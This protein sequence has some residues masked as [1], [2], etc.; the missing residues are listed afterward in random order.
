M[1]R[2]ILVALFSLTL[3]ARAETIRPMIWVTPSEHAEILAK[4]ESQPWVQENFAALKAKVAD[5]VA[6]HANDRA[7]FLRKIPTVPSPASA[8]AHPTFAPIPGNMASTP[9]KGAGAKLQNYLELGVNCGAL[10]Y[11]TQDEAYAACAADIL[12]LFVEALVQ[13][14]TDT[15]DDDG[16]L[17]YPNDFLYE[18]R[19]IGDQVPL[20]YDFVQAYLKAGAKVHDIGQ[21]R[22]AVFNFEHAQQLFRTYAHFAIDAG[23]ID[24]NHPVF[25]MNCLAHCALAIDDPAERARHFEYLV[26]KDTAHQDSLKKVIGVY[27]K[28]GEVWPE[29]FQYSSSVSV[30][31]TYLTALAQRHAPNALS[32]ETFAQIPL[33]LSRLRQFRFPNGQNVRIGDG[34]RAGGGGGY[35]SLE[36]AYAMSLRQGDAKLREVFGGLI[37]LGIEQGSYNRAS[38]N[39]SALHLL[40]SAPE[41]SGHASPPKTH[42]TDELPFAGVVLQRNFSPGKNPADAL[43]S[44][45]YGGAYVHSHASGMALE[46]YGQGHVLGANAGKGTYTTD[47]HENY[48]RIFAAHNCVIVNGASRS[49]G[50]WVELGINTVEKIA[51]DPTVGADPVSPN[52]SF[53]LTRFIDD[54]GPDAKATQERLVGIVRTSPT[55]GYYVDVFRSRSALT[56][57]FHDY[58][59]HNIGDSLTLATSDGILPLSPSP[60]RFVPVAGATWSRNRSFLFPGWHVFKDAQTSAPFAQNLVA[61]FSAAKLKPA[62]V[63]MLATIIGSPGREYSS[64]LAPETR[65]APSPYDQAPTPVLIIRQQGEAW[66][67]PFAV[68][69]EPVAGDVK[70][71][72]SIQSI[73][74][75]TQAGKFSGLKIV[76]Q[77]AD[78]TSTQLILTP[79]PESG[80]FEDP[81]LGVAFRGRYAVVH[82]D[83][84]GACTALYLGDGT[85]LSFKGLQLLSTSGQATSASAELTGMTPTLLAS[86]PCE[87]TLP[88]GRKTPSR[89]PALPTL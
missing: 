87:L 39:G 84:K 4:I 89:P 62:A 8:H 46:L 70:K 24:N 44:V 49:S 1:T 5:A 7:A 75:L 54:R 61:D 14:K 47:E 35:D 20:I 69:Y 76:S 21:N 2:C 13:M 43:M 66:D 11:L 55:T 42:A 83:A 45:L 36:I 31:V 48:R 59:Y 57:Q 73:T 85:Q 34:P 82:L 19:G 63:H 77:V 74:A 6:L 26:S 52:H 10:Y 56:P 29:S 16:G 33:S 65:D 81:A 72:R 25:E 22:L 53:T 68:V 78:V 18:A 37:N 30:R 88:D 32:L 71:S 3:L 60:Q 38:R 15:T 86:S 58:L 27:A 28:S 79:A 41:I 12:H 40:W 9:D 51:T 67:R 23:I 64:A 17:L 80:Q 50:G